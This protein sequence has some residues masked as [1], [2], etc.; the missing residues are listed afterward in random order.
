MKKGIIF[1]I[2]LLVPLLAISAQYDDE[3]VRLSGLM[4]NK[5]YAEAIEGYG[6]LAIN[7]NSP[8]WLKAFSF[9]EMSVASLE[10]GNQATGREYFAK[11]VD[12]GYDDCLEI[13]K[14]DALKRASSEPQFKAIIQRMKISEADLNELFWLKKEFD[15]IDHDARMMITANINRM[16]QDPTEIPQSAIPIRPT[17]SLGVIAAREMVRLMQSIQKNVVQ[18]SDQQRIEHVATMGVI[19]GTDQSA[20]LLSKAETARQAESRKLEVQK[21]AYSPPANLSTTPAPCRIQ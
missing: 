8:D 19:Q 12:L 17:K 13:G 15:L 16:D 1:W 11:A 10:S 3:L 7:S 20:V 18:Q 21:R 5:Q 4:E 9:V 2:L 14:Q 6:K